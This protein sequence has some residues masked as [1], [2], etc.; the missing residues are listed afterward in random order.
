[1]NITNTQN[2]EKMSLAQNISRH[3]LGL[4][5]TTAGISHLTWNRTEFLAQVPPW[6]PVNADLVVLLSGVVEITLGLSLILLFKYRI[7][8]GW[9][10]AAFF[11]LVFPG[12][13]AQLVEHRNAFGLNTE[14]ARWLRLPLQPIL[15]L[16]ALWSTG[17]WHSWRKN[18][19]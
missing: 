14:L 3:I 18:K 17:A 2:L 16:V 4:F 19:N 12:N 1:M 7:Q 13:I 11:V 9:I 8:V 10:V 15:I 5:L 6:I